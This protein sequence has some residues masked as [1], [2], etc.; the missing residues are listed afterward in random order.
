[1]R[2]ILI[3]AALLATFGGLGTALVI[4]TYEAT[5]DRIEAS[6]KA[7]LLNNL[8]NII[9]ADS[10]TNNLLENTLLVPIA[11]QLGKKTPTVI[12]RAWQDEIPV[13]IAFSIISHE[14]Y[15]GE[16]KLLIAIKA[17]GHV[18]GVRVISHK[19]TPGLGDKIELTKNDWILSFND[20]FLIE[21]VT[22]PW[23]VKKDGGEFDQFTGATIT[24]RAIVNAVFKALDYYN[25][26]H[27]RL[28][29]KQE[30]YNQLYGTTKSMR[31]AYGTK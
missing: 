10:Y 18:S 17:N 9:P 2:N 22:T 15:S 29:L 21:S 30:K 6:E 5:K 11:S 26:N 7:N 27:D 13:A 20:K 31:E 19:E 4:A 24:P 14:G 8:N 1:M 23:K 12:Y 16:I 28:F 3:S 25:H